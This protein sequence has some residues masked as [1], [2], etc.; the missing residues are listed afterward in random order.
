[1]LASNTWLYLIFD[2][3]YNPNSTVNVVTNGFNRTN[4][5]LFNST[6]ALS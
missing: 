1:M 2:T 3:S 6:T 4:M 5:T